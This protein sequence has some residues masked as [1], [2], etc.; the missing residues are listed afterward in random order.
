MSDQSKYT[1]IDIHVSL[2]YNKSVI[3]L[4][5]DKGKLCVAID[6]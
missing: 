6:L 5:K 4:G 2:C 3:T 1:N